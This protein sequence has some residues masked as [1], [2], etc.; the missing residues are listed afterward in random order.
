MRLKILSM[1]FLPNLKNFLLGFVVYF[2][3][4]MTLLLGK[5]YF[6]VNEVIVEGSE[7]INGLGF[8]S[9]KI[10]FFIDEKNDVKKIKAANPDFK[11]V[12]ITKIWPN[13]VK[14]VIVKEKPMAV[15]NTDLGYLV[16]SHSGVV[17]QR[18]KTNIPKLPEIRYYQKL[19]FQDFPIGVKVDY[20]DILVSLFLIN[21]FNYLGMIVE[22]ID[23]S[24]QDML[25]FNL[26][27][28]KYIFTSRGKDP[29][30]QYEEFKT[31]LARLKSEKIDFE[32][33]DFRFDQPVIKLR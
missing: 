28:K 5:K 21:K 12:Q 7:K 20:H 13:Q 15:L 17:L 23:I 18:S 1:K 2:L 9:N 25:I 14:L 33:I 19:Y 24:S 4:L 6:L 22:T 16:L 11:E 10:I 31:L 8:F 30:L 26:G 3:V 27:D 32:L 29:E